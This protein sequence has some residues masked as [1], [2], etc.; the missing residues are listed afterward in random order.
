MSRQRKVPPVGA[1]R[2]MDT[3]STDQSTRGNSSAVRR[4][5]PPYSSKFKPRPNGEA[6]V[7][8]GWPGVEL[9]DFYLALPADENPRD[10]NWSLLKNCH[11]FVQ[12]IPG[13][14]VTAGLLRDLGAELAAVN[15]A[16]V[17]LWDGEHLVGSWWRNPLANPG[18]AHE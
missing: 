15:A 13:T 18:A 16:S 3:V 4:R 10:F 9:A 11:V 12:P 7:V 5:R 8:I 1:E 6:R 17:Y 2:D 14:R